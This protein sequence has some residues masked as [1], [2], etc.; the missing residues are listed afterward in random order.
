MAAGTDDA[1]THGT[2]RTL[3]SPLTIM[4]SSLQIQQNQLRNGFRPLPVPFI[5]SWPLIRRNFAPDLFLL[6]HFLPVCVIGG[7][8]YD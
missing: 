8:Q 3:L 2:K 6:F 7:Y 5:T 4:C 1:K